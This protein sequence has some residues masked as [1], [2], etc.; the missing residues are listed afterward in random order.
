MDKNLPLDLPLPSDRAESLFFLFRL[1]RE[2]VEGDSGI[3]SLVS[4]KGSPSPVLSSRVRFEEELKED[5]SGILSGVEIVDVGERARIG[6][7]GGDKERRILGE[8]GSSDTI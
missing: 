3:S 1:E 6:E 2:L 8:D 4:I 7:C 5:D